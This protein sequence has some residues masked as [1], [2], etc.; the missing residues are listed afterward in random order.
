MKQH[1]KLF[2]LLVFLLVSLLFSYSS[3]ITSTTEKTYFI[4]YGLGSPSHKI[5]KN[6]IKAAYE[7]AGLKAEFIPLP[8]ARSAFSANE[9]LVDGD[10]GRVPR[11]ENKYTDLRRVNVKLMDLNGVAFTLD[12]KI[13]TYDERLLKKYRIGYLRGTLWAESMLAGRD[14]IAA[15]DTLSL[16]EMLIK[17]RFDIVLISELS[18]QSALHDLGIRGDKVKQLQPVVF[19]SPLYHYVNKKNVDIIPRLEKALKEINEE[20]ILFFYTGVQSPQ[21]EI[22][23]QGL[24]EV[25]AR[26]G[27]VCEL[28]QTGS[29]ERALLLA[30]EKG[31]GDALRLGFIKKL[32]PEMTANLLQVPESIDDIELSVYTKKKNLV[33]SDWA[34]LNGLENGLRV[35][36]KILEKNIPENQTRFPET[37]RLLK[38]LA[39]NRLDTVTEHGTIADFKIQQLRLQGINKLTPPLVSSPGYIYIHKRHKQL[40]PA[41]SASIVEMKKEGRFIQ[42]KKDVSKQ[43]LNNLSERTP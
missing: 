5:A 7:R 35:G 16:F 34:S 19:T 41:I 37:E 6:K 23:Q 24:K 30:N 11:I 9:G 27:K 8:H 40:I 39:E 3:G 21:F 15:G 18:G 26:M 10:V 14:A 36:A 38:M 12:P 2:F 32:N 25:F 33:V 28:R 43:L 22:L 17:G 20:G 13:E 29:S 31:D 4:S 42:I 1:I